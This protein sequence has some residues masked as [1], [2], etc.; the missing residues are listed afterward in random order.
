MFPIL[1][2]KFQNL[3]IVR[4][5][6]HRR[7]Y[8]ILR[9]N[10]AINRILSG[11]LLKGIP[12]SRVTI[13]AGPSGSGKSFLLSNI[14]RQAQQE[15]AII[16][17]LDSENALDFGYLTKIGVDVS[18]D[19]FIPVSVVTITDVVKVVSEFISAYI[20]AYGK[21]NPDAPKVI[22][23]LD[24]IDMLLTESENDNFDSGTQ[25][26]DQGQRAKQMKHFLRTIVSRIKSLN[27][28]FIGTHQVYP[29]DVMQGEGAWAINNAVR[30]SASQIALIT[31]L[32]LKEDSEIIGIR[33]RVETFKS[34]FAKLGSKVEV[35]VPYTTGMDPLSGSLDF[36]LSEGILKQTGAWY[37]AEDGTKFMRKNFTQE[38]FDRLIKHPKIAAM[39][40]EM[41]A[42][43]ETPEEDEQDIHEDEHHAQD[44][45]IFNSADD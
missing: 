27:I 36:F 18:E 43:N 15:G 13:L 33:M 7:R 12:Q 28:T 38:I 40:E 1:R 4:W 19:R 22:I 37:T 6:F 24:S 9:G 17:A 20:K 32:R 14:F 3:K 29:A 30:Y 2:K 35:E 34:R 26:G 23:G 16:L 8:G 25:K 5:I 10:Y 41:M 39:E 11:S 44:V 42:V 45:D 21:S 31:K